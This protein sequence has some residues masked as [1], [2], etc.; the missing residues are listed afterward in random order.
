[1]VTSPLRTWKAP[2]TTRPTFASDGTT[3]R[4]DSNVPRSRIALTRASRSRPAISDKRSVSRRSAPYAFTSC[5]P[6]KLSCTPADN[7]PSSPCAASKYLSTR[8][9]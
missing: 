2:T 4:I 9:W 5:T 3:S 8:R 7:L 6:S 1:M